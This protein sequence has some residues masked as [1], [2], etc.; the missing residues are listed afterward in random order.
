MSIDT[1]KALSN[2]SLHSDDVEQS[3]LVEQNHQE[4][5]GRKL[6]SSCNSLVLAGL[7]ACGDLS[8][9]MLKWVLNMIWTL[10]LLSNWIKWR[11]FLF[12]IWYSL[13]DNVM[14]SLFILLDWLDNFGTV[15]S[16]QWIQ[17]YKYCAYKKENYTSIAINLHGSLDFNKFI[18]INH[19]IMNPYY[20]L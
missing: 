12:H 18:Y 15:R 9:T 11:S 3:K 19:Q 4:C 1:L 16:K 13:M 2:M 8:V 6:R 14:L 5:E 10:S 20:C 17:P 7:H